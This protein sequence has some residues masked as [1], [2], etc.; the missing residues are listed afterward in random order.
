VTYEDKLRMQGTVG[1]KRS[2]DSHYSVMELREIVGLHVKD[3]AADDAVLALW[4][5]NALLSYGLETM[6]A[7]GFTQKQLYTWVKQTKNGKLGFNMGRNFRNATESALIGT[8]GK[9]KCLNH[10]QRNVALDLQL[11]HS[12]KPETLQDRLELMFEG[13]Y[14]ELF[15]RRD[16]PGW[17][18][19]G[20]ECPSTH[21]VDIRGWIM[22]ELTK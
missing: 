14:L 21:K 22:K 16:R 11:K 8:R 19:T 4:V 13:P 15:A 1:V 10:S 7:W 9:P 6:A 2:A 5:P 3:L 18:C 12:Q 17:T 20:L